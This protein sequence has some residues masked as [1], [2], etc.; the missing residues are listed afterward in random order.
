[1]RLNKLPRGPFLRTTSDL[2]LLVLFVLVDTDIVDFILGRLV[3]HVAKS[4][5]EAARFLEA[6]VAVVG[7][8]GT[9][10]WTS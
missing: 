4:F 5:G 8:A 9:H 6:A 2:L 10:G 3:H 7:F 1:M